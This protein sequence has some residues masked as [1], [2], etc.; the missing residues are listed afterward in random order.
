MN[1][2]CVCYLMPSLKC[3]CQASS[4]LQV[5]S[6]VFRGDMIWGRTHAE[7]KYYSTLQM[8]GRQKAPAHSPGQGSR[9][10]P[11]V[12]FF[13]KSFQRCS[14]RLFLSETGSPIDTARISKLVKP[15]GDDT[16]A[17]LA[18]AR[19]QVLGHYLLKAFYRPA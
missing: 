2:R 16:Y 9:W 8:K 19:E 15:P 12:R 7:R 1:V 6:C 4:Q 10:L 14:A 18:V 17:M 5:Y 3:A 11:G 13:L